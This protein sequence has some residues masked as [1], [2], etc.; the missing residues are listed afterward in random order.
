MAVHVAQRAFRF[1]PEQLFDL[2]VDVERYPAFVPWWEA[3]RVVRREADAYMTDQV[4]SL[5]VI[6]QRFTSRTTFRRPDWI[7][8]RAADGLFKAFL[9]RWEFQRAGTDDCAVDLTVE[10]QFKSRRL[11]KIAE[12]ITGESV[13]VL[14]HSF[15]HEAERRYHGDGAAHAPGLATAPVIAPHGAAT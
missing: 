1:T 2:V 9:L 11:S 7:E 12:V 14:M 10:F 3:A 4:V 8:V 6:R 13:K 15:E 5:K